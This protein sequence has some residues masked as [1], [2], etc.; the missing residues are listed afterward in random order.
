MKTIVLYVK[1][2]LLHKLFLALYLLSI[3]VHICVQAYPM[4][5]V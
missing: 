5:N 4:K 1:D 3:C 2:K